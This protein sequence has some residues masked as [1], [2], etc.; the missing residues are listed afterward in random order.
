M[1][2]DFI[3][4][5]A[6]MGRHPVGKRRADAVAHIDVVAVDGNPTL[7]IDLHRSQRAIPAGAV[8]L[9]GARDTG[10]DHHPALRARLLLAALLPDRVLLELVQDLRCAK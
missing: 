7:R 6:Q 8:I 10:A 9:G 3:G 5:A 4:D 2:R 1:H